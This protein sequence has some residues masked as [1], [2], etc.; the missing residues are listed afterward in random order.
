M[1]PPMRAVL[2]CF[3]AIACASSRPAPSSSATT[4]R[5]SFVFN[6]QNVGGSVV[7]TAP[8]GTITNAVDI[9]ENG[10]GPHADA[11]IRLAPDGTIASLDAKGHTELN[12]PVDEHFSLQS[13]RASWHSKEEQGERNVTAPAFFIPNSATDADA[14]LVAALFK[15][16]GTLQLLP[17]GTAHIEKAGDLSAGGKH[18]LLYAISG[19]S[20]QPRYVWTRD[21]NTFFAEVFPGFWFGEEGQEGVQDSLTARQEEV[22]QR[23]DKELAG[24]LG[25]KPPQGGFALTHARV[26][27]VERGAWVPDQTVVVRDGKIESVSR[28][29]P[30]AGAEVVDLKGK[31][32][33]PGLWDMH[34]HLGPDDGMLNIACGVTTVR[35]VGNRSELLDGFKKAFD[36]GSAI[37]PRVYRAGFIEGRGKDA[38]HAEITATNADEARKAVEFFHQRGYEMIKIYNSMDPALVPVLAR[39]AHARGMGVTGHIPHGMLA[40]EAVRAGYDGVEHINQLMLNFFATHETETRTPLRFSL[41][42][43]KAADFDLEGPAAKEFYALLREHHTVVDPTYVTFEPVYVA[44]QGKVLP[45]WQETVRRLPVQAQ[46]FF[47]IGGLPLEGKKD[48]Y[49]RSWDKALRMAKVLHDEHVTVVAGTD[50]LAGF[51]LHRELELFVQ[52]GLTPAEALQAATVVPAR[53]MKA[54]GRSGSIAAG[55][56]AD[57]V[58]IDGDPLAR[59]SDVRKTVMT[60]RGGV[61]YATRDL[62]EAS[63]ISP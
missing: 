5:R 52:G 57:L 34:A 51:S 1:L 47:L 10:R 45:G 8:D 44:E 21:D 2:V 27:D 22:R 3:S 29:A 16:G 30:P 43:D 33:L 53:V 42:G 9:H 54:T 14:L 12:A 48:L 58:V 38:A 50:Y 23:R 7:T 31:A 18:F 19:L 46:R 61:L 20:F 25:R 60:L 32:L 15:H 4:V 36:E 41:V 28:D 62:E 26:L 56:D 40:N 24:K 55:K 17:G 13:G 63:G 39:E 11:V 35:D 49:A 59:I 37:G 6:G